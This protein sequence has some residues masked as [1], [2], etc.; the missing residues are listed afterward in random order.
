MIPREFH[1]FHTTPSPGMLDDVLQQG[2][3]S[4]LAAMLLSDGPGFDATAPGLST[5]RSS[6]GVVGG[7]PFQDGGAD[8]LVSEGGDED[9]VGIVEPV[10]VVLHDVF[11]SV[12]V[13]AGDVAAGAQGG[14]DEEH[15]ACEC[16]PVAGGFADEKG[17]DDDE[18]Q[19]QVE[20][21]LE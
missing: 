18:G 8:D 13:A 9:V 11:G 16:E 21:V 20:R 2:G 17:Q 15:D 19:G 6:T 10:A 7:G 3:T 5:F 14:E 1:T 12:E 4:T